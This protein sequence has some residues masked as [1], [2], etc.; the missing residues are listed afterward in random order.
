[1]NRFGRLFS[2]QIYGESHGLSV[3]II[4]DGC[5]EGIS[6]NKD[7]FTNDLLRR[8]TGDLGTSPRLETDIPIIKSGVF[9][10]FTTGSPIIIEFENNDI[11]SEDYEKN[12]NIPR[13]GHSDFVAYKKYNEFNDY[14]GAGHFS[15]RLTIGLVAAGVIAKKIISD[16]DIKAKLISAGGLTD[17]KQA[18]SSAINDG[19]SIGGIVE[20]R[21]NNVPIGLGEPFF[22]SIESLISHI[23]FSIPAVKGIEFGSGFSSAAMRGS[24]HNDSLINIDGKTETNNSGGINGGLSNGNEIVFRV[25]FKP[26]P[27]ISKEQNSIDINSGQITKLKIKGRHDSCI[28]LR[29]SVIVEAAAAIALADLYLINKNYRKL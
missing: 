14:R 25:A 7:D 2:V 26:T 24:E 13:P 6:L 1:M 21:I 17:I 11:K 22:D 23:I 18:V 10:D 3:G 12:K 4:I 16:I 20:C 19:D 5:P 27:S 9:N 15:G 8:K 29:T 28:A